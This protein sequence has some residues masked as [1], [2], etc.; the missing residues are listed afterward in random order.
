M[1][2]TAKLFLISLRLGLLISILSAWGC[3]RTNPPDVFK[4]T[5][6]TVQSRAGVAAQWQVEAVDTP[7][8]KQ[9][10]LALTAQPLS[11]DAAVRLAL[12]RNRMLQARLGE[13]GIAQA[14]LLAASLPANPEFSIHHRYLHGAPN[15]H[16]TNTEVAVSQE[17]MSLVLLPWRRAIAKGELDRSQLGAAESA[18]DL[19]RQV[20][21]A[22]F[23]MR[24]RQASLAMQQQAFKAT[25]AGIELAKAQHAAGNISDLDLSRQLAEYQR[26][27]LDLATLETKLLADRERLNR[28]M[29][30]WGEAAGQWT[31]P[32][33]LPDLPRQEVATEQM[34][35][36]AIQD[37][38]DLAALRANV[39]ALQRGAR[40]VNWSRWLP[41][42][43]LGVDSERDVDGSR[44]TGPTLDAE[45]PIFD[46]GQ[47]RLGRAQAQ[48]R[49][50]QQ[51]LAALATDIRSE[52]R[53]AAFNLQAA[54]NTTLYYRDV[55]LPERQRALKL[56][57]IHYQGMFLG[58]YELLQIKREELEAHRAFLESVRDYWIARAAL[59]R[60][61]G[62]AL[63][64]DAIPEQT[65]QTQTNPNAAQNHGSM[66]GMSM[67]GESQQ[68]NP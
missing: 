42:L 25:E 23:T 18:L 11:A 47:A 16:D 37:R 14:E 43:R 3:A 4:K 40:L 57:M 41:G 65:V 31:M 58:T 8:L 38:L 54:R 51:R 48:L 35:S 13:L 62:G 26:E 20:Q 68:H 21:E 67:G 34:E 36:R 28:L 1:S 22:Y 63:R 44:V 5:Q 27:R 9:A 52:V 46:W 61:L 24:G 50:A 10:T 64:A 59:E 49:Q 17:V 7:E 29:G 55:L 30:L 53:E 60:A 45:I 15:G 12:L 66:P 2:V 39:Q 19:V 6:Q 32:E 33:T 56:A